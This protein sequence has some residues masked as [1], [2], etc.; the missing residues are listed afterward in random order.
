M[1]IFDSIEAKKVTLISLAF[2]L[3]GILFTVTIAGRKPVILY[4]PEK[5][6]NI[7][8]SR[9]TATQDNITVGPYDDFYGSP[10]YELHSQAEYGPSV[11][12][13]N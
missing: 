1:K 4:Q 5:F 3:L 13:V 7:E 12:R 10:Y 9:R 2:C 11:L 6:L 8:E